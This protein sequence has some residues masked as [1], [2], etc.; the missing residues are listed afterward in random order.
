MKVNRVILSSNNN[1][2]Y[3]PFWNILSKLYKT[4]FGIE[5]VLIFLGTEEEKL[6]CGLSD[7]Y[8]EIIIYDIKVEGKLAWECTW[9]LFYFTKFFLDDNCMIMGIDQIPTGTYFFDLIKD[10][11][12]ESYIMLTDDAYKTSGL[13][14]ENGGI[15]PSAYHIA[16]GKVFNDI[17]KFED[18]FEEELDKIKKLNLKT[19]WANETGTKTWG[20]DET[21]SSMILFN[22]K[23]KHK[24]IGLSKNTEFTQRRIDCFRNI[25]VNYNIDALRNNFYIE[26]HSCRPYKEHKIWIDNLVNNIPNFIIKK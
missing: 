13:T 22:N 1:D 25:E 20:Y 2:L 5:P 16:K 11:D 10:I 15:S 26:C 6:E 4:K 24:I 21:Y 23:E 18:T 3:Y 9:A 19:M 14:W 8:G 7:E 17:Y 12:E